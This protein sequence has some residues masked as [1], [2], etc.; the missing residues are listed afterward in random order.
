MWGEP[1]GD[2]G[3]VFATGIDGAATS[4]APPGGV[5]YQN[6]RRKKCRANG[7]TCEGWRGSGEEYCPGHLEA[8]KRGTYRPE[9]W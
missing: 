7:D 5:A 3:A 4:Q 8:I 1:K 6:P 9:D 2:T